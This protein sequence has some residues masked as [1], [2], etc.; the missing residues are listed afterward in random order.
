M[1]IYNYDITLQEVPDEIS[2]C[3]VVCGCSLKCKNCHSPHTWSHGSLFNVEDLVELLKKYNN[4]ITCVC[5]MGGEWNKEELIKMLKE[6]H[7]YKLKTCLYTG[8]DIIDDD[9]FSNLDF[10]KTGRWIEELGGLDNPNT[11][12]IFLDINKNMKLN[13]KFI[14]NDK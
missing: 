6:S 8:L 12:Q 3:I 9:I 11:N 13:N 2:L 14:R 4:F 5:F 1:E 10:L 7:S